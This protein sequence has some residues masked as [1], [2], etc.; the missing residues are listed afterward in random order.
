MILQRFFSFTQHLNSLQKERQ[1]N[2]FYN[3]EFYWIEL[4]SKL[5]NITEYSQE[6]LHQSLDY[7]G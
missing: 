7:T 4:K 6:A 2:L 1:I 3:R 5:K